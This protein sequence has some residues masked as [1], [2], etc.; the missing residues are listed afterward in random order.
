MLKKLGKTPVQKVFTTGTLPLRMEH[1]LLQNVYLNHDPPT[2]IMIRS[3]TIRPE[4]AHHI[5]EIPSI[6]TSKVSALDITADLATSLKGTLISTERII[7]FVMAV[8]DADTLTE[9][10]LCA[11][12]HS[13]MDTD[14]KAS[15]HTAWVIGQ[16][17]IM[18]ATPAL[19]Q[20]IDFPDVRYIIFQGGA[21][22]LI[23]YYQGAG[24]GGRSGSRCDVFTVRDKH[25][26][27]K[28][29]EGAEDV[30]ASVE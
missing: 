18:V 6:L 28:A 2:H 7:I 22:G 30:E 5:V 9:K 24:R 4:L 8:A 19:I 1:L 12:Y 26:K 3:P 23:S 25:H 21:Y 13:E 15:N 27:L 10:L 29:K 11:K 14:R 20:G 17:T 16:Y